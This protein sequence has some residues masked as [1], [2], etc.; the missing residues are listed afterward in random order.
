MSVWI[1]S[2]RHRKE[3]RFEILVHLLNIFDYIYSFL[4]TAFQRSKFL[5]EAKIWVQFLMT[6]KMWV[7]CSYKRCLIKKNECNLISREFEKWAVRAFAKRS[8][9]VVSLSLHKKSGRL[10]IMNKNWSD[11]L[12]K[13]R[14]TTT[15]ERLAIVSTPNV[16]GLRTY[17]CGVVAT[18]YWYWRY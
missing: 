12:C 18:W 1:E 8:W 13:N 16:Y 9:V 10:I 14:L 6:E 5:S 7:L 17:W 2:N 4:A 3:T 15:Q 11:F